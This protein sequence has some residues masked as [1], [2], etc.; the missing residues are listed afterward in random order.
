MMPAKH[1]FSRY[2]RVRRLDA[3]RGADAAGGSQRGRYPQNADVHERHRADLPGQVR[4]VPP[5]RLDG[6]DVADDVRAGA[7]VG[8]VD[9]GSRGRPPDAAVADRSERR[10]PEVQERPIAHR[11]AARHDRSLGGR[12]RAAGRPEGHAAGQAVARRS[13]LEFR[14]RVRPERAGSDHQVVRL[15]DAEGVA[16][17]LGQARHA[18]R[19]HRAALGARH[20]NPSRDAR[21]PQD[22]ASRHRV[23]RADRGR[24]SRGDRTARA[25]HGVGSRQ[26]GRDDAARYGQAAAARLQVPLG[27]SLLAGG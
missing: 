21:G 11:R 7:A 25:L 2:C 16:G 5:A 6:A 14:G 20:R 15:H 19:H 12:G 22:H 9:Q 10:H 1:G 3:E 4:G 23:S 24:R 17:R 26:A 8:Q 27:H 18:V 13:G